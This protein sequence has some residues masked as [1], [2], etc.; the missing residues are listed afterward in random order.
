MRPKKS[1]YDSEAVQADQ[2]R[3]VCD[4]FGRV[5]DDDEAERH[6]ALRGHRPGDEQWKMIMAGD[7]TISETAEAF[8][9]SP[10]KV[11]KLLITGGLYDT[12]I[13]R[14]VQ[15]LHKAGLSVEEIASQTSYAP[16]TVRSYLPY[17][18]VIYNLDERSVTADRLQ[19]FKKRWGGYKK[20]STTDES[21]SKV[22]GHK[23]CSKTN[24]LSQCGRIQEVFKTYG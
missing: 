13:Y 6:A 15:R 4:Y 11:R 20:S 5:F 12:E 14:E 23:E 8:C 9:I 22:D 7:P 17:E 2:V 10:M 24:E 1:G 21:E 3:S 19:R 16:V 18:R